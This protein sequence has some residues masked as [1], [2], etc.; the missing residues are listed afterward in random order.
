M[1]ASSDNRAIAAV[2]LAAGASTRMGTPKQL[3]QFQGRSLLRSVTETAIAAQCSPIVIVLGA[4]IELIQHE[5]S[6]L[7]V[8]VVENPE[9]QTGMGSS[10]RIGIQALIDR[11]TVVNGAILLL[12]D[13]PFLLPSLIRQLKSRYWSTQPSIVA[14]T[15]QN[16]VGVPALFHAA[17]FPELMQLN[18]LEGAKKVIQ[19]HRHAVVTVDF[20]EGAIDIDTPQDY[21][22]YLGQL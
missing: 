17:L 3:L 12:C 1:L 22:R 9:W 10:I 14:S 5:V 15:Y 11:T 13:Q 19:R 6:D 16:T 4:R 2:I 18:Q 7:P 21:Q 8:Q 20:P